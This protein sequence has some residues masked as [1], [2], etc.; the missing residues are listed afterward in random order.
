VLTSH[1]SFATRPCT[2]ARMEDHRSLKLPYLK[3]GETYDICMT[4][5]ILMSKWELHTITPV[6]GTPNGERK[7]CRD[8]EVLSA[9]KC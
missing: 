2:L 9:L 4:N 6:L 7:R 1:K 8:S 5:L 3:H